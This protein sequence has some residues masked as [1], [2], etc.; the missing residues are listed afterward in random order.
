MTDDL[1]KPPRFPYVG[2]LLC[3][4]S[5]GMAM[6]LWLERSYRWDVTPNELASDSVSTDISTIRAHSCFGAYVRLH[7]RLRACTPPGLYLHELPFGV[8][9]MLAS[10][11]IPEERT[12]P[13]AALDAWPSPGTV[14]YLPFDM[15]G[16]D[17]QEVALDGRVAE[18]TVG[19]SAHRGASAQLLSVDTTTGRFTGESIAGVV[20][21][22]A[23]TAL[24]AWVLV[25]W[26]RQRKPWR[27]KTAGDNHRVESGV[28]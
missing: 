25:G 28:L 4:A 9:T 11:H 7:G 1:P 23:M 26:R 12:A 18:I 3:V 2:S 19:V 10:V 16:H 8:A 21:A 14:V 24:F 17:G 20:V 22:A 6:W 15:K 13:S 27:E 5:V